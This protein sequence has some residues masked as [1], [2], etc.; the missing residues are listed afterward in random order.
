[1][2]S[3]LLDDFIGYLGS[4][5]SLSQKTMEGYYYDIRTFLRFMKIR[6]G[7]DNEENFDSIDIDD[8]DE[9][10][11]ESIRKTDLY[12]FNAYLEK[13]RDNSNRTKYRKLSAIRTFFNYLSVK[14]NVIDH[15]PIEDIDMPKLEKTLPIALTLDEAIKFLNTIKLSNE[16]EFF[17]NRDYAIATLFLNC[18]M[19][20]SE[21]SSINLEDIRDDNSL[22][23]MG[24]GKK[25]RTVYLNDACIKALNDY[26]KL[27]P[28]VE[29]KALFLSRLNKRIGNRGIQNMIE[30]HILE[31]GLDP[32]KY[33]VHKLRHTAATLMYRY[34]NADLRS[35]QEVL[36]HVSVTTTQIYTHVSDEQIKT[37]VENNP[38]G[39]IDN[40]IKW[41][42]K[43]K[44]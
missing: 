14:I 3:T 12:A 31:A 8:I 26:I 17:K 40:E 21:L 18:G 22:K 9:K 27:R 38:L 30:K 41:I 10:F 25:E 36:G 35:L 32:N 39:K 23:I 4:T 2:I 33:T 19:R 15:N 37:T 1:M 28:N 44:K 20:L 13:K 16:P 7:L 43:N 6:R 24:K 42:F 29:D 5:R 11:L 34:G